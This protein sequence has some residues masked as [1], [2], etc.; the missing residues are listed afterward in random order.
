MIVFKDNKDTS[1]LMKHQANFSLKIGET[2]YFSDP[3]MNTVSVV[4][5]LELD[6][7]KMLSLGKDGKYHIV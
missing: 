2:L 3:D 6:E 4:P 7:G 5:V 1:A